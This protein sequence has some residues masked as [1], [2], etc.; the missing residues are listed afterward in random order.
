MKDYSLNQLME[1]MEN[2]RD[3]GVVKMILNEIEERT[4]PELLI[5]V[6][7]S[8]VGKTTLVKTMT[9][10]HEAKSFTTRPKRQGETDEYNFI[11]KSD[12]LYMQEQGKL[13]EYAE[14]NGNY[15]GLSKDSFDFKRNNV[16]IVEPQG[17]QV[18]KERLKDRFKITTIQLE[19]PDEVIWERLQERGVNQDRFEKDKAIFNNLE[20]DY[21]IN[22]PFTKETILNKEN[23]WKSK[24]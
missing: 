24:K 20:V 19:A 7:R 22:H 13:I 17:M 21:I 5:I 23:S 1:I 10:Y 12:F 15:Y 2:T 11:S 6:G 8:C 3:L 18:L 4:R 14:Y 16:V 9:E